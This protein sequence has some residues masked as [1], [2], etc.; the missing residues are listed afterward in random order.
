M[1]GC[2]QKQTILDKKCSKVKQWLKSRPPPMC[3]KPPL[4]NKTQNGYIPKRKSVSQKRYT[5]KIHAQFRTKAPN[6]G[7]NQNPSQT[8]ERT[9]IAH[10]VCCQNRVRDMDVLYEL[11]IKKKGDRSGIM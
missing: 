2:M 7:R 1:M 6:F 5:F 3:Q 11:L 9:K 4:M 10:G 8:R